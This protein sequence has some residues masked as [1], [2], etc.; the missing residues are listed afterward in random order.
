MLPELPADW[1]KALS[2]ELMK[3]YFSD[4]C[5]RLE[6]EYEKNTIFP[7]WEDLFSAF[8]ETPVNAVKAVILGQDPYHEPGQ[9]MGMSFSV[10]K[11]VRVPPS[12]QNMYKEIGSEYG[13]DPAPLMQSGDLTPWA[14]QGVLLLNTVLTVRA[15]QAGS[16]RGIGWE[17]FTDAVIRFVDSLDQPVVFMLWGRDA[18][19]KDVLLTNP[20]HLTLE[21]THPSPFSAR[22]GFLGC[23]HFK[24]ANEYLTAHGADPVR[25][26]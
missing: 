2:P 17:T 11:G 22:Y 20:S 18:K 5:R 4:L 13:I 21:T 25:W 10:R 6:E 19:A 3:P 1:W 9:A 26:Y 14:E 24:K 12:L 15:G 8:R 16:M 23:G 7:P